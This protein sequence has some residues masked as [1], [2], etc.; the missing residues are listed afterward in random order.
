MSGLEAYRFALALVAGL[1]V[2]V[3]PAIL[4]LMGVPAA[5][6][7]RALLAGVI[8]GTTAL[9]AAAIVGIPAFALR[10]SP[11]EPAG[12]LSIL[13]AVAASLGIILAAIG[14]IIIE[15]YRRAG[16]ISESEV[17]ATAATIVAC[18]ALAV[19]MFAIAILA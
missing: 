6:M 9:L 1:L 10:G 2:A 7:R 14:T 17:R 18:W 8:G 12:D 4:V 16:V 11:D 19:T 15:I 13:A 5:A 3:L